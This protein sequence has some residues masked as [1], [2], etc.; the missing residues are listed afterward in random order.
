MNATSLLNLLNTIRRLGLLDQLPKG[1]E[2]G[3]T[4]KGADFNYIKRFSNRTK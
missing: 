3:K 2:K 1:W 4:M